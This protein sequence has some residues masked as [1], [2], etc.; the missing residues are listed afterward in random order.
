VVRLQPDGTIARAADAAKV[1]AVVDTAISPGAIMQMASPISD[2]PYEEKTVVACG[3]SK[4]GDA[5]TQARQAALADAKKQAEA[6][7]AMVGKK[8]GGVTK[9]DTNASA[10]SKILRLVDRQADLPTP[11][12][13]HSSEE[14]A[15][16]SVLTVVFE[17]QPK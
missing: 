15:V 9:I 17:L 11:Y 6:L 4:P 12:T 2:N 7:A 14:V 1:F 13:G 10:K 5:E 16:G 3:V 8:V